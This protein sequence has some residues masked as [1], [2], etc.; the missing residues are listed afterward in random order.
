MIRYILKSQELD[1]VFASIKENE[2]AMD[3]GHIIQTLLRF[4]NK[5]QEMIAKLTQIQNDID[6]IIYKNETEKEQMIKLIQKAK[7]VRNEMQDE[8]YQKSDKFDR[9]H[10]LLKT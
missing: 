2:S 4:Q 9:T 10:E 3:S 6:N 8:S 7:R 5:S 1:H